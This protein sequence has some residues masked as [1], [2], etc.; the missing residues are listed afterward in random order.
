MRDDIYTPTAEAWTILTS[1]D[2]PQTYAQPG[3]LVLRFKAAAALKIGDI[4]YVSALNTVAKS[5]TAANYQA[6]GGIVVGYC[7]FTRGQEYI[8]QSTTGAIGVSTCAA[9]DDVFV[10]ISGV[11]WAVA[12]AAITAYAKVGAGG[13]TAGRVDDANATAGQ[14]V[15]IALEAASNAGDLIRVFVQIH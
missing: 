6:M 13:T 5:T 2:A 3:G 15:G 10:C 12:D 1:E 14:R 7:S 8:W 9:D 4:V 11:A